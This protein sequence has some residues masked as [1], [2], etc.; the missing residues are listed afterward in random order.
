MLVHS[1]MHMKK[2]CYGRLLG[3]LLQL[4][5]TKFFQSFTDDSHVVQKSPA[6]R[7]GSKLCKLLGLALTC[8]ADSCCTCKMLYFTVF[9]NRLFKNT[10]IY[11]VL[12]NY[13]HKTLQIPTNSNFCIFLCNKLTNAK[14]LIFTAFL[15]NDCCKKMLFLERWVPSK[16]EQIPK[17]SFFA[18][19]HLFRGSLWLKPQMA[20]PSA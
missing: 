11:A 16:F 3:V 20:W 4:L 10:G 6:V 1:H 14:T 17:T 7:Q 12:K 18:N 13:L 8:K 15:N 2:H 19:L 9:L 5:D